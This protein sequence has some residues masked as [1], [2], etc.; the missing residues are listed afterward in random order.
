C[1]DDLLGLLDFH[2]CSPVSGASCPLHQTERGQVPETENRSEEIGASRS[3]RVA[4]LSDTDCRGAKRASGDRRR[5][6]LSAG[7]R[8]SQSSEKRRADKSS[9]RS[10]SSEP[11]SER[12]IVANCSNR[13][14]ALRSI[15]GVFLSV[16]RP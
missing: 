13:S 1:T 16:N 7:T 4:R 3:E 8:Q 14:K 9:A 2:D 11:G 10:E 15:C 6:D 12:G 5:G